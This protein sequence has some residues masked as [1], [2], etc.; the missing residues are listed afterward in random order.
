VTKNPESNTSINLFLGFQLLTILLAD[1]QAVKCGATGLLTKISTNSS[2]GDWNLVHG[3]DDSVF[4]FTY[5]PSSMLD[6]RILDGW[7]MCQRPLQ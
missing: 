3:T 7:I 1:A 5:F 4:L 6:F 2:D